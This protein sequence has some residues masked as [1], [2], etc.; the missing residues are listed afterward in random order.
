MHD[1]VDEI[2]CTFKSWRLIDRCLQCDHKFVCQT[3][4]PN[5]LAHLS[6]THTHIHSKKNAK[7]INEIAQNKLVW[8]NVLRRYQ[9]QWNH[10][11]VSL[12]TS[13]LASV[14]AQ[15]WPNPSFRLYLSLSMCLWSRNSNTQL[16]SIRLV[17][18]GFGDWTQGDNATRKSL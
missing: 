16:I 18:F 4:A 13:N 9:W 6:H 14:C 3:S 8:A 2:F 1:L 7:R 15:M 11:T 10:I 17:W 5:Q 12:I